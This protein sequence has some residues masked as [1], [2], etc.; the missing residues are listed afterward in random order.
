[1]FESLKCHHVPSRFIPHKSSACC[2]PR[3]RALIMVKGECLTLIRTVDEKFAK[4]S[5]F[6]LGNLTPSRFINQKSIGSSPLVKV[7]CPSR[8]NYR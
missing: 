5:T 7:D 2:V 1:M 8:N 4:I 6:V 3:V